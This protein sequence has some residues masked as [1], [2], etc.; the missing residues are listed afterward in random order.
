VTLAACV[1]ATIALSAALTLGAALD[2]AWR[3][4]PDWSAVLLPVYA[5]SVLVTYRVAIGLSPMQSLALGLVLLIGVRLLALALTADGQLLRDENDYQRVAVDVAA[6]WCC[7][8][9]RPSG[10]SI[11][12]GSLYRVAGVDI[13][14]VA[15]L[16]L[17]AA[18]V[19]GFLAHQVARE[20]WGRRAGVAALMLYALAPTS[21]LMTSVLLTETVYGAVLMGAIWL[22][23]RRRR[24]PW[25]WLGAG[26][27]LGLSQ[28][29]RSTSFLLLPALAVIPM[30]T[31]RRLAP[32]LGLGALAALGF[33]VSV[34]PVI[35]HNW[36]A[37]GSLSVA[38]SS[39]GGWSMYIGANSDSNGRWNRADSERF[40]QMPGAT[41][42]ERSEVAADAALQRITEDPPRYLG[43]LVRKVRE[44]WASDYY[45]ARFGLGPDT[46]DRY[47]A[48]AERVSQLHYAGV[49]AAAALGAWR[50]RRRPRRIML[51]LALL[52]TSVF[53]MH[54]VV[55]VQPRY[56]AYVLPWLVV[57]AASFLADHRP[58]RARAP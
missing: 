5:V 34:S 33:V 2:G 19:T 37:H 24:L 6:G 22:A 25:A 50:G 8:E 4:F 58:A 11:L 28:Y 52:V 53:A 20:A 57:L 47:L 36:T 26:V 21:A 18:V 56:H 41:V 44:M 45:G 13:G 31:H 49:A 40:D 16:N 43:L 7:F 1:L 10:F 42:W 46:P 23:L 29:L 17:T 3:D 12:L 15:V 51:L 32:G 55:E 54:L 48:P 27:V 35:V 14:L 38:T 30:L 39:Y 9:D